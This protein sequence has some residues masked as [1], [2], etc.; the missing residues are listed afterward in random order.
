M[1][2]HIPRGMWLYN[3]LYYNYDSISASYIISSHGIIIPMAL[4][5]LKSWGAIAPLAPTLSCHCIS[6]YSGEWGGGDVLSIPWG[7][8]KANL[9]AI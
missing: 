8:S 7:E 3:G 6:V 2:M 4:T 5:E 9:N 1:H